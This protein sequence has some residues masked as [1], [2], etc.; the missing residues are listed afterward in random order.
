MFYRVA[1]YSASKSD[2]RHKVQIVARGFRQIPGMEYHD[3]YAFVT[4]LSVVRLPLGLVSFP[5][6]EFDRMDVVIAF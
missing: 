1:K 6:L 2:V 5:G 3:T 4:S